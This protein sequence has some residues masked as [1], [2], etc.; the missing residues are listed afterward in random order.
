[1]KIVNGV[2]RMTVSEAEARRLCKPLSCP[3]CE[4][5]HKPTLQGRPMMIKGDRYNW[6]NQPERLIYLGKNWSG[7]GYWHQFA[8][9]A[10]PNK[11]WCEVTESQLDGF[12]RTV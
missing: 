9:V 2:I 11:V 8:L 10:C 5:G 3:L 7:N 1:M 4:M 6:K 12:E